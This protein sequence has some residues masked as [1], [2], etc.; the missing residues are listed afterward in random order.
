MYYHRTIEKELEK[1]GEEFAAIT[2]YGARQ[3]GK[4]TVTE[5]VFGKKMG[6]VTLDDLEQRTLA[7]ENPRL[8]LEAHPYPLIID[9]VQKAPELLDAVKIRIDDEKMK[10]LKEGKKVPLMYVLTGSNLT[11]LDRKVSESLAGRTAIVHLASLANNEIERV[12]GSIFNPDIQVIREKYAKT[13]HAGLI[14]TRKEIFAKIFQGGMPEYVAS[15]PDRQAFFSSYVSTYLEKDVK[16]EIG[17]EKEGDFLRFLEFMALRTGQQLNYEDISRNLGLDGRTVRRWINLLCRTGIA[18]LLEPYAKNL[19]DRIVRSQKFYFLDTG[20][21]AW[22]CKWPNAE[23]LENGVMNGAFFETY[24]VS[25]IIKSFMNAGEDYRRYVYY[26]R[27]RD[28]KEV[29]L[30]IDNQDVIY[31][32]EIKKGIAPVG[33]KFNFRFLS[34]YG[35]RVGTGLVLDSRS[36]VFP[37]NDEVWYVPLYMVGI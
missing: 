10:C 24:A 37:V 1:L 28:Q 12:R 15:H 26:Y 16:S 22:L 31:P 2:I 17:N 5:M 9:E 21:C 34:K 3:V 18:V 7:Q 32:I 4:S 8:F 20:L 25:E 11:E 30:I 23:M 27:D 13:E 29:D 6:R 19:T 33:R 36:D 35:K 14:E